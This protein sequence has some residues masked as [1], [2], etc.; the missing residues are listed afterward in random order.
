MRLAADEGQLFHASASKP[1]TIYP[2]PRRVQAWARF[3]PKRSESTR[4]SCA[5]LPSP[6]ASS[7]AP[8]TRPT[9]AGYGAT[10]YSSTIVM[11]THS[12]ANRVRVHLQRD[13]RN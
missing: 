5:P 3:N 8:E 12:R 7:S 1:M 13:R 9:A 2:Y 11:E 6:P 4:S 10:Q